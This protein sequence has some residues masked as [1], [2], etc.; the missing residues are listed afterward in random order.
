MT[1]SLYDLLHD[2]TVK[3]V[4]PKV[5]QGTGFFVAPGLILTCAH[6]VDT[7]QKNSSPVEVHWHGQTASAQIQEFRNAPYPDLALLQVNLPNHPCV[8]LHGGAEPFSQLY[9][10]GYPDNDPDGAASSVTFDSEGWAGM[11]QELLKFKLGQVRPGRSGS[12]LLNR[13]TGSVCGIVQIT[14]DRNSLLGGK[15]LLTQ[16]IVREFPNLEALQKQFHQQDKRWYDC[17]TLQQRKALSP[18]TTPNPTNAIEVFFSY[19]PKDSDLRDELAKH[20]KPMKRDGLI[21]DWYAGNTEAGAKEKEEA[22]AHL[23]TAR[24]IL[25]LVSPDFLA[26]DYHY[27]VE[28]KRALERHEADEVRVIPIILKPTEGWDKTDFKGLL[29]LP[30]DG[31]PVSKWPDKDD[32]FAKIAGEIRTVANNLRNANPPTAH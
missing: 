29:S 15:G 28:M 2:C 5:S 16:A 20:L 26:S 7:A 17:L 18:V 6:V 12:P 25:M 30:R 4:V 8:L 27:D 13:D 10:Y 9:S 22:K 24:I 21:S 1:Q 23:D 14:L 11:Q 31:R 3:L 19:H 32:A